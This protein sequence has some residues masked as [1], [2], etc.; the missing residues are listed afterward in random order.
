[1]KKKYFLG[2][3][4]LSLFSC[5]PLGYEETA[6][7]KGTIIQKGKE[8]PTSGYK[9]S[10]NARYYILMKEDSFGKVIRIDVT[11][12]KWYSLDSGSRAEFVESKYNMW[13]Y[14]NTPAY[15]KNYYQYQSEGNK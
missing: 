12:P 4:L 5:G 11:V 3:V 2:I 10:T 1:M 8:E 6:V 15:N 9:R 14:G 7:Y 13:Y